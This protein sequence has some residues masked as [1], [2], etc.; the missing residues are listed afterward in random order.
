MSAGPR[1]DVVVV[2]A[3]ALGSATAWHL[4]RR[5]V[6]VVLLEQFAFGHPN[7]ASHDTSR[8]LRRSYHTPGYVT[9]AGEAYADWALLESESGERLVTT[10]G[11]LDLFPPGAA[12]PAIDYTSSLTARGVPYDELDAASVTARWPAFSLPAGTT[13]IYQKDTSVVPAGRGTATMQ[14]LARR[15]GARLHDG[16]PVIGVADH[17]DHVD[18]VVGPAGDTVRARRVVL[19]ADAWTNDLLAHLGAALPL[20]VLRE[21]VTY[22]APA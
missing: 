8:I 7:G 2:G 1:A 4:A 3:G 17:G 21:Q 16:S 5:G 6:D 12:I 22:F 18:V 20:T 13:A 11:G 15:C 19:T 14:R 9:L 10:T